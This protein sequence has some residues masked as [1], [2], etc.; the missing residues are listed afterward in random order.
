MYSQPIGPS[1]CKSD[2]IYHVLIISMSMFKVYFLPCFGGVLPIFHV[3]DLF[4][5]QPKLSLATQWDVR[6]ERKGR[7]C[8]DIESLSSLLM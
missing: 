3:L 8:Q 6:G 4:S 5:R 7:K 1:L 2:F